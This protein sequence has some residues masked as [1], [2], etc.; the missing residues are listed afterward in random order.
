[1]KRLVNN[2]KLFQKS[3]VSSNDETYKCH[4]N[5]K[6]FWYKKHFV[7]AFWS[8][9]DKLNLKFVPAA[10]ALDIFT[11]N[12]IFQIVID[13]IVDAENF[14]KN[15]NNDNCIWNASDRLFGY[16]VAYFDPGM[17]WSKNYLNAATFHTFCFWDTSH[18]HYLFL[19]FNYVDLK[20]DQSAWTWL[21]HKILQSTRYNVL[22]YTNYS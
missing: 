8:K 4:I 20:T 9:V 16:L 5:Q 6:A 3:M 1:M 14:C 2:I 7:G 12:I 21:E 22:I 10:S 13:L 11:W 15:S 19:R 17:S 18:M